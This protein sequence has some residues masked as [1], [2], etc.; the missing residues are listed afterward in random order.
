MSIRNAGNQNGSDT[1]TKSDCQ[2]QSHTHLAHDWWRQRD[3]RLPGE[4]HAYSVFVIEYSDGCLYFGYTSEIVANRVAELSIQHYSGNPSL[5][6]MEHARRTAYVVR[7]IASGL[8]QAE[9]AAL[10]DALVAQ[11]PEAHTRNAR[12]AVRNPRCQVPKR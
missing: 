5:F 2:R 6:V 11:S 1:N 7:C 9:A 12:T 10:R 3:R 8:E 4:G